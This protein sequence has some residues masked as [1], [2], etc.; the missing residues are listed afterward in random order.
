MSNEKL[1]T[2]EKRFNFSVKTKDCENEYSTPE[3][4]V[5]N[6][7]WKIK[8]CKKLVNDEDLIQLFLV[9]TPKIE[10]EKMDWSCE[11]MATVSFYLSD[12]QQSLQ[13]NLPRTEFKKGSIDSVLIA[14]IKYADLKPYER[15]DELLVVVHLWANI[16]RYIWPS[17]LEHTHITFRFTVENISELVKKFSPEVNVR[18]TKWSLSVGKTDDYLSLYLYEKRYPQNANWTWNAKCCVK[19]LSFD[20]NIQPFVRNINHN[21]YKDPIWGYTRFLH[22]ETLMDPVKKY[23]QNDC[24]VLEVN[25]EVDPPKPVLGFDQKNLNGAVLECSI[26]FQGVIGREPSTTQ[27]GHL[28]CRDCIKLSIESYR[29]CPHCNAAATVSQIRPIYL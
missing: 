8:I 19:L 22:M 9:C 18:G 27:C 13:K 14:F 12:N 16:M 2:M 5:A 26:C 29:K 10:S 1:M 3:V 24:I 25:L 7:P 21:F 4:I 11:A 20:E 15:E 28:F 6:I 23:V 17:K